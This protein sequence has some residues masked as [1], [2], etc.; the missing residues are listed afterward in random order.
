VGDL[1]P[2]YEVSSWSVWARHEIVH[3][4]NKETKAVLDRAPSL[5]SADKRGL[6]PLAVTETDD[7]KRAIA[8]IR[9]W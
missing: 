1:V 5:G 7:L 6:G 8:A 4:L 2:G 3:K 9:P